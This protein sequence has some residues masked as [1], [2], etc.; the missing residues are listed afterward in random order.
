MPRFPYLDIKYIASKFKFLKH[1]HKDK[2]VV[3]NRKSN[4]ALTLRRKQCFYVTVLP[5]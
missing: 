2:S 1:Q 3:A 4:M 5:K